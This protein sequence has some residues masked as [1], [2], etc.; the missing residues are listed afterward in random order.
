M[1]ALRDFYLY[2]SLRGDGFAVRFA[3]L[4]MVGA[5]VGVIMFLCWAMECSFAFAYFA[6]DARRALVGHTTFV[7]AYVAILA[8]VY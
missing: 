4:G 2:D 7:V 5:D 1:V 8:T 3:R 6:N